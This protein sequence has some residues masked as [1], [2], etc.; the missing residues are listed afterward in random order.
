MIEIYEQFKN[1]FPRVYVQCACS[2]AGFFHKQFVAVNAALLIPFWMSYESVRCR[3][4]FNWC[5]AFEC[6][7]RVQIEFLHVDVAAL[8]SHLL[9]AYAAVNV[10]IGFFWWM[11]K[12]RCKIEEMENC[13]KPKLQKHQHQQ[14]TSKMH[15]WT[16]MEEGGWERGKRVDWMRVSGGKTYKTESASHG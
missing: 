12:N 1:H 15:R 3:I 14:R 2:F 13:G 8:L 10:I 6:F 7:F 11:L 16:G 4:Q 5:V 9:M